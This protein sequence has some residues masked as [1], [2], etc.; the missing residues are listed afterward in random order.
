MI[1]QRPPQLTPSVLDFV[2]QIAQEFD[3]SNLIHRQ[4]STLMEIPTT[5]R[6]NFTRSSAS[7]GSTDVGWISPQRYEMTSPVEEQ[8]EENSKFVQDE[9]TS[10]QKPFEA[11]WSMVKDSV[12]FQGSNVPHSSFSHLPSSSSQFK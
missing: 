5:P 3:Q 4:T 11:Y 8:R 2:D 9:K 12:A 1:I 7:Q 6:K 10:V